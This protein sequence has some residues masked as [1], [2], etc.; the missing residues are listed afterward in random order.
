MASIPPIE[1]PLHDYRLDRRIV[2]GRRIVRDVE[3]QIPHESRSRHASA[4]MTYLCFA[5]ET[6]DIN[7]TVRAG[8]RSR[9]RRSFKL[10]SR[11]KKKW[12]GHMI[13]DNGDEP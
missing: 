5:T 2:E 8:P 6:I 3:D 10:S 12:D 13:N 7:H 1:L 4:T 9:G 11:G